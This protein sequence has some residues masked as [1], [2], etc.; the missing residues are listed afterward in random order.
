[1]HNKNLGLFHELVVACGQNCSGRYIFGFDQPL[2]HVARAQALPSIRDSYASFLAG[3]TH[4]KALVL[5]LNRQ[6]QVVATLSA[7][8]R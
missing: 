3:D 1:M 4:N 5:I 7:S 6:M 8:S 2:H